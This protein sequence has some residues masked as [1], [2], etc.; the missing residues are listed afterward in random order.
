MIRPSNI[1][2]RSFSRLKAKGPHPNLA[3]FIAQTKTSDA[4]QA[5][6]LPAGSPAH[7]V[8]RGLKVYIET[9]GCQMNLSDS[10]IVRSI[11]SESGHVTCQSELEADVI[12]TNTCAIREN[13]ESKVWDR[14]HYFQSIRKKN[15]SKAVKSLY[16]IVGVLGCMAERLKDKLLL[17]ESVD[18]VCGPDA[19]RDMPRLLENIVSAGQKEANTVL[20]MEETYADINPVREVNGSS[21]FVSIMR[22]CNN[23][24][25][26]CIVPFTRGRERSRPMSS[27]LKEVQALSDSGVKEIVLLGQ[28]V[29]GY[30]DSSEES[31]EKFPT[32]TY[33]A[34]A[35]FNNLNKSRKR[36]I[37]GARFADL[38]ET[39]AD[40]NPEMRIRFTSPHPKDFPDDVL[41]VV[42]KKPNVCAALHLPVQSGSTSVL[43]RMRRG[44]TREAFLALVRRCREMIPG[45]TISTD[46][47]AG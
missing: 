44:Y 9:Y 35:G 34:A 1:I 27:I 14:L 29:N 6:P 18:F 26:F 12:L 42:G 5:A 10:E 38:L 3:D 16:P 43:Q 36:D 4:A 45:V 31:A 33:K 20:S 40:V 24:C 7:K 46:I 47:I 41:S 30:H 23:M 8:D 21:A 15:R 11:L 39:L 25:S 28:N 32:T 22:G 19:Y 2:I 17:E 37:P 13:A